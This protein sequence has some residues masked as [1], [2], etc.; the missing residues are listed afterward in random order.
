MLTL[1]QGDVRA[2]FSLS[3]PGVLLDDA[4]ALRANGVLGLGLLAL[5]ALPLVRN[6]AVLVRAIRRSALR[7]GV[8]AGLTSLLLLLLYLGL[9]LLPSGL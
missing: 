2:P 4:L 9:S 8:L 6:A 5:L 7:P 3:S 1:G